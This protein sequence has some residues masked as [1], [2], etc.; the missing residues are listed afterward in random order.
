MKY[1]FGGLLE[2]YDL[3]INEHSTSFLVTESLMTVNCR[4]QAKTLPDGGLHMLETEYLICFYSPRT[5]SRD[6]AKDCMR[7]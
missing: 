5:P 3:S 2:V 6:S 1:I 7:L 4:T